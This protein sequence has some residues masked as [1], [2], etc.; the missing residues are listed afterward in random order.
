MPYNDG[1]MSGDTRDDGTTGERHRHVSGRLREAIEH[2]PPAAR[3]VVHEIIAPTPET[4]GLHAIAVFEAIKGVAVLLAG[5]GLLALLHR[6]VQTIAERFVRAIHLNPASHYPHILIDA[7][8]NVTD[9][10]LL[11]LAAMASAY[12]AVRLVEAYGLWHGRAWAEW[13]AIGSGTLYLPVEI[14]ELFH[15]ATI[16]KALV[17]VT[18]VAMVLY[19]VRARKRVA[20]EVKLEETG[21]P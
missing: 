12:S 20:H 4:R 19:L 1:T 14:Y 17:L 18:N 10:R 16:L 2:A 7:A 6:D 13:F 9:T 15:H 5:F 21:A 8:S 3:V 11:A